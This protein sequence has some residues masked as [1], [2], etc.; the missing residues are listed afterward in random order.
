M[1]EH[2]IHDVLANKITAPESLN[3]TTDADLRQIMSIDRNLHIGYLA[4][5]NLNN[6]MVVGGNVDIRGDAV[7]DLR[8]LRYVGG[9]LAIDG[10]TNL[11][12]LRIVRGSIYLNWG[13][14]APSLKVV[15]RN[16]IIRHILRLRLSKLP[17]IGGDLYIDNK[18]WDPREAV[19]E[20]RIFLLDRE[21]PHTP[22]FSDSSAP[23][24]PLAA[25]VD[26]EDFDAHDR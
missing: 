21:R 17:V 4:R 19:L 18:R 16:I 15:G 11:I 12:A 10:R 23:A 24:E 8:R 14:D 20:R 22:K 5:V 6:L 1:F 9:N 25:Q 7:A 3:I 2:T 26:L 13:L